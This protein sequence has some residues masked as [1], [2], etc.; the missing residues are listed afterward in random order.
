MVDVKV[1]ISA[2][3]STDGKMRSV[4]AAKSMSLILKVRIY[5]TGV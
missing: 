5:K 3:V 4:W 2:A 1:R